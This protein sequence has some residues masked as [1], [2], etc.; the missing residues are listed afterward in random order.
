[1]SSSDRI[2]INEAL[3]MCIINHSLI[4]ASDIQWQRQMRTIMSIL[5]LRQCFTEGMSFYHDENKL[6][7]WWYRSDLYRTNTL[8]L[9]FVSTLENTDKTKQIHNTICVGHHYSQPNTNNVNKIWVWM[10]RRTGHRL[11]AAIVTDITTLPQQ[12]V[13]CYIAPLILMWFTL[14]TYFYE[15]DKEAAH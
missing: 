8:N 4:Y 3:K 11:Y 5:L 1:M 2:L 12:S 10:Y 13:C 6:R 15:H 7:F 14:I 9:M